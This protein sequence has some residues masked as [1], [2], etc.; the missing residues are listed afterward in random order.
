MSTLSHATFN[1]TNPFQDTLDSLAKSLVELSQQAAY[2]DDFGVFERDLHALFCSAEREVVSATLISLDIDQP[3]IKIDG[4]LY[5]R[6]V[7]SSKTYICSA[8]PIRVERSLYRIGKEKAVSPMELQAGII[9]GQWTPLAAK[10]AS[11]TVAHLTPG[12]C[13][14]LFRQM[15]NMT[16][17]KSSLD[18]LPKTLNQQWEQQRITFETQLRE[19]ETIPSN[20]VTVAASLDGVMVPLKG[21]AQSL[22][23]EAV[24]ACYKEASC[25]SL[26]FYDAEGERLTTRRMGRMPEAKKVTLKS[27]LTAEI[28]YVFMQR[29]DLHLVKVADGAKDNWTY[30]TEQCPEGTEVVDFFHAVN[31]LMAAFNSVHGS[32]KAKA[33]C[34]KYR[35]ILLDEDNGVEK[36]IRALKDLKKQYPKNKGINQEINYFRARRHQMQY[37]KL[38]KKK[39]PIGSGVI[40]ATCKSLVSQRLKRSGMRWQYE[41]GQAILN[42]RSLVQSDRFDRGWD[43]LAGCYKARVELMLNRTVLSVVK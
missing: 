21:Q 34:A 27:Q 29:P 2:I 31:H 28:D 39:L 14:T 1:Q 22:D 37:A 10:Q 41:G 24:E 4:E 20:A 36:V 19:Q 38:R 42:L 25:A 35:E 8:G 13:E 43:M 40:E 15:G 11:W 3:Q 33:Q 7:R 6:A 23:K 12:E 17:S 5:T 9:D 16:P 18:R 26:S 32:M 30:F